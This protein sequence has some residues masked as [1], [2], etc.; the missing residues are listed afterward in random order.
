MLAGCHSL[1][2]GENPS[3]CFSC[4]LWTWIPTLKRF[5]TY[6]QWHS[7][8][9]QTQS[10]S[11]GFPP[12]FLKYFLTTGK[13]VDPSLLFLLVCSQWHRKREREH[14]TQGAFFSFLFFLPLERFHCSTSTV[15]CRPWR[16][17]Q[18]RWR[19]R[20]E[21]LPMYFQRGSLWLK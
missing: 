7:I 13:G 14:C 21:W 5:N 10:H 16:K 20:E 8:G 1:I 2:S 12:L 19:K 18:K 17:Q 3:L 15:D 6:D 4:L 9:K 11:Q